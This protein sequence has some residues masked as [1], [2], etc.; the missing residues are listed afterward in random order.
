MFFRKFFVG[1]L[2]VFGLSSNLH[3][4]D[5]VMMTE[6]VVKGFVEDIGKPSTEALITNLTKLFGDVNKPAVANLYKVEAQKQFSTIIFGT[7]TALGIVQIEKSIVDLNV[8]KAL[9]A[10]IKKSSPLKHGIK[11]LGKGMIIGIIQDIAQDVIQS[12]VYKT[13]NS[14]SLSGAAVA[15]VEQ[16]VIYATSNGNT[17]KILASEAILLF[18]RVYD[19]GNAI[20]EVNEIYNGIAI[21]EAGI[22]FEKDLAQIQR[23]YTRIYSKSSDLTPSLELLNKIYTA[24]NKAYKRYSYDMTDRANNFLNNIKYRLIL[25]KISFRYSVLKNMRK[26]KNKVK[27]DQY[28]N[29]YFRSD[30]RIYYKYLYG[31]KVPFYTDVDVHSSLHYQLRTLALAYRTPYIKTG[32]T[33]SPNEY[34]DGKELTAWLDVLLKYVKNKDGKSYDKSAYLAISISNLDDEDYEAD[35][36]TITF[37]QITRAFYK[38][39]YGNSYV[40]CFIP[41]KRRREM[42]TA[43]NN[44][45]L[46]LSDDGI[47]IPNVSLALKSYYDISPISVRRV[48][49]VPATRLLAKSFQRKGLI[50]FGLRFLSEH[51]KNK[52][53]MLKCKD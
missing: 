15:L 38:E 24:V 31:N 26:Q 25:H 52:N 34:V 39:I 28:L 49:S 23:Y 44:K 41:E 48:I 11:S 47:Y 42:S 8:R 2:L 17:Y 51:K 5:E 6:L 43:V 1:V 40:S 19:L 10:V 9:E 32:N 29:D 16:S 36:T 20:Y 27:Y 46:E 53:D 7:I 13:T 18:S 21:N 14:R 33:L 12:V 4:E 22:S 35:L 30:E 37:S 3:A 45:L 50:S